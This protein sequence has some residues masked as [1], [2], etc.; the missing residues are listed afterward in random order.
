MSK[1][2]I[3]RKRNILKISSMTREKRR[4]DKREVRRAIARS[5]RLASPPQQMMGWSCIQRAPF[6]FFTI[7]S[8]NIIVNT[9]AG[10]VNSCDACCIYLVVGSQQSKSQNKVM[11]IIAK[12]LGTRLVLCI[13]FMIG[14]SVFVHRLNSLIKCS[15]LT[16]N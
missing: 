9:Y 5:A 13:G 7:V 2:A 10:L 3:E 6:V 16:A 15:K 14:C 8:R 4:R 11:T 1:N 12:T